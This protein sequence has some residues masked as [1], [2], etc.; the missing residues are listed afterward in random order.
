MRILIVDDD[1]FFTNN[2]DKAL[3][4]RGF[5]TKSAY[6]LADA[7]QAIDNHSY[8]IVV[9]DYNLGISNGLQVLSR[10]KQNFT[11]P[12]FILMTAHSSK[13]LAIAA[14]NCG[15][16]RFIEKPFRVLELISMI[17]SLSPP[18]T[19]TRI[20]NPSMSS[21]KIDGVETKLTDIEFKILSLLLKFPGKLI[22]KEE[23]HQHIYNNDIKAINAVNT[24]ISNLRKKLPSLSD[25]IVSIRGK[26]YIYEVIT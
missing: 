21:I 9:Q 5:Y 11:P 25:E 22:F 2:L 14:V 13:E 10:L 6:S 19:N 3:K 26:G 23:L 17:E 24:H 4:G 18:A 15:V 8:D 7:L 12:K 16:D 1:I 20:L